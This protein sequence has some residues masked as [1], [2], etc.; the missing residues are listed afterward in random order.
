M[1][2]VDDL[3]QLSEDGFTV[4]EIELLTNI[5]KSSVARKLKEV[6]NE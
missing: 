1:S 3:K 6:V 2:Q 5:P 4:R